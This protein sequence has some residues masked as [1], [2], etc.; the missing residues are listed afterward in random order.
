MDIETLVRESNGSVQ[1]P[2]PGGVR[3]FQPVFLH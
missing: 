1:K 3:L 2:D